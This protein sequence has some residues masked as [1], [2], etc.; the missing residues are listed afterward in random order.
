MERGLRLRPAPPADV[1]REESVGRY[2]VQVIAG[3]TGLCWRALAQSEGTWMKVMCWTDRDE[4]V[5]PKTVARRGHE[6][7]RDMEARAKREGDS[8]MFNNLD[9]YELEGGAVRPVEPAPPIA[10]Q[11]DREHGARLD[12]QRATWQFGQRSS[13]RLDAGRQ[14]IADSPLFGGER[15]GGLFGGG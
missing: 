5:F 3:A 11:A 15:Q 12:A 13:R 4:R 14:E 7:V 10:G 2:R 9:D 6:M 8:M 1:V